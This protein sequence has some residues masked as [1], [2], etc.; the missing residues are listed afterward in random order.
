M[1]IICFLYFIVITTTFLVCGCNN[2][3]TSKSSS[4]LLRDTSILQKEVVYAQN[5][6]FM[7]CNH[8]MQNVLADFF[9]S[10]GIVSFAFTDYTTTNL[11]I[12][13]KD[14]SV[15]MN[16][17]FDL[18]SNR[19]TINNRLFVIA[20]DQS[21]KDN[22]HKEYQFSPY[23]FF[24]TYYLLKFEYIAIQDDILEVYLDK[25]KNVRKYIRLDTK[26]F[27]YQCWYDYFLGHP[28]NFNFQTNPI[29]EN[30]DDKS[31]A[32]NYDTKIDYLFTIA[33]IKGDWV[34]IVCTDLCGIPC[35]EGEKYDGWI[36]WRKNG[37]L[38]ISFPNAC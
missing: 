19:F 14:G 33:E 31:T 11:D 8:K 6:D 28:V 9:L 34:K 27:L 13:N 38:I 22:I 12:L 24:P 29:R 23:E 5:V 18:H 20:N 37:K 4:Q 35:T 26:K 16:I 30:P 10:K 1:K 2:N 32:I 7:N 36:R 21:V 3:K 15:Y 17:S 25:D